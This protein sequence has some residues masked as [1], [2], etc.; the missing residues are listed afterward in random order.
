MEECD[1]L[2][3]TFNF[4]ENAFR[5]RCGIFINDTGEVCLDIDISEISRYISMKGYASTSRKADIDDTEAPK[6]VEI[7]SNYTRRW[8]ALHAKQIVILGKLERRAQHRVTW[9]HPGAIGGT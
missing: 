4:W 8:P 3:G 5:E 1:E 6:R 9:G 7:V 2:L